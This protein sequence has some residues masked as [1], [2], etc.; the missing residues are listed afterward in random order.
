VDLKGLAGR[1]GDPFAVDEADVLLEQRGVF[2]LGAGG[3]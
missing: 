3:F 1:G 2:E